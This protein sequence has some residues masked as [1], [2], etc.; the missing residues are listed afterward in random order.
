LEETHFLENLQQ[1]NTQQCS[2]KYLNPADDN[3]GLLQSVSV[4]AQHA[5][6]AKNF[7]FEISFHVLKKLFFTTLSQKRQ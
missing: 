4:S 3:A 7:D 1:G 5:R 6:E 2:Y